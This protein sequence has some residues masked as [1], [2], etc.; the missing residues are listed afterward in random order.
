VRV[1]RE[2]LK[3]SRERPL[4][5]RDALRRL[6][7]KDKLSDDDYIELS[8]IC[9]AE[10]VGT[11]KNALPLLEL[12]LPVETEKHAAISILAVGG[13]NG[14]NA[15]AP[16]SSLDF[17][18][19]GI[20]IVF[21]KNAAGKTGYT[22]ILKRLA[23]ARGASDAVLGNI[24]NP[25]H[26]DI[27]PSAQIKYMHGSSTFLFPWEEGVVGPKELGRVSVFDSKCVSIYMDTSTDTAYLP[28]GLELFQKMANVAQE[29]ARRLQASVLVLEAAKFNIGDELQGSTK[30]GDV[31]RA[32]GKPEA[33][34]KIESLS[35]LSSQELE[36]LKVINEQLAILER[37]N[38]AKVAAQGRLTASRLEGMAQ[39]ISDWEKRLSGAALQELINLRHNYEAKRAAFHAVR[40]DVPDALPGTGSAAWHTLWAAAKTFSEQMAYRGHAFPHTGS[41]ARCV[42][43][44]QPLTIEA[45]DRLKTFAKAVQSKLRQEAEGAKRE[46]LEAQSK[47]SQ[48][49][50]QAVNDDQL[51]AEL[52]HIHDGLGEKVKLIQ[53]RAL[54]RAN[55]AKLYL[56]LE[57]PLPTIIIPEPWATNSSR[58]LHAMAVQQRRMADELDAASKHKNKIEELRKE[59]GE[60][61]ARVELAK[62]KQ[63]ILREHERLRELGALREAL[64]LCDTG[65]ITRKQT[66]LTRDIV[67]PTLAAAFSEELTLLGL[68]R[69]VKVEL[70]P[71]GSQKGVPYHRLVLVGATSSARISSILSEGEQKIASLSAFLTDLAS[72]DDRSALI[73]DDPVSSLDADYRRKVAKRLIQESANRQ[74]VVFTHDLP[75]VCYLFEEATGAGVEPGYRELNWTPQGSGSPSKDLPD[76]GAGAE[77]RVR[78]LQDKLNKGRRLYESRADK[79]WENLASQIT[80]KLRSTWE[81]AVEE[82]LLKGVVERYRRGVE[83]QRL[84]KV[85]I[86]DSDIEAIKGAMS[87]LSTWGYFHDDAAEMYP[88][89]PDPD[90]LQAEI[91]CVSGWI[92]SIKARK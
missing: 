49:Q 66:E 61:Q 89:I 82:F 53:D 11:P 88:S 87:R 42:F 18:E 74:V 59:L 92:N 85:K 54:Q 10:T 70:K 15:I 45:I 67:T 21:G 52:N 12:H 63:Q 50:I 62:Q 8:A 27:K 36:R 24:F 17:E 64:N 26:P 22:R 23:R 13:V 47:L 65:Q 72:T 71:V 77:R 75:F 76:V 6:V 30:V 5:Q 9:L 3:W 25:L 91:D 32:L 48:L 2:L 38:P 78:S 68:A 37:E 7:T 55:E 56:A 33:P 20:T 58:E 19:A 84:N 73:F 86:L 4:W 1:Y 57:T 14:V 51:F 31:I 35:T 46:V 29:V 60:L 90:E 81:R 28:G 79:D 44:Q 43:C 39:R 41:K 69:R 80:A 16:G 40:Q 34:S 83:T